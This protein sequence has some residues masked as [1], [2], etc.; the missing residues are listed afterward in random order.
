MKVYCIFRLSKQRWSNR[1]NQTASSDGSQLLEL[2]RTWM[3]R[4]C[5]SV[6]VALLFLGTI[7]YT[8][9]VDLPSAEIFR[10]ILFVR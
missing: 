5:T 6:A 4:W 3:A 7:H 2:Y 9:L 8:A 10:D 1:G